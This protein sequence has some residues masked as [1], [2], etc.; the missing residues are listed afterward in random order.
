MLKSN[1]QLHFKHKF[2]NAKPMGLVSFS[3]IICASDSTF[4]S[5]IVRIIN[6]YD[7]NN[8]DNNKSNSNP[9]LIKKYRSTR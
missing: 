3:V 6:L 7:N 5:I 8:N 2:D 1:V 9:D 4:R